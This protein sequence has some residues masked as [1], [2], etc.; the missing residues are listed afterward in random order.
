MLIIYSQYISFDLLKYLT[1]VGGW[2]P[3]L[4]CTLCIAVLHRSSIGVLQK[5]YWSALHVYRSRIGGHKSSLTKIRR[6]PRPS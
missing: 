3:V 2:G 4:H 5:L 6:E 1:E